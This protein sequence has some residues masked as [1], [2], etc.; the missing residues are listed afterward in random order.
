MLRRR[1]WSI[2]GAALELGQE[3]SRGYTQQHKQGM[4]SGSSCHRGFFSGGNAAMSHRCFFSNN[5]FKMQTPGITSRPRQGFLQ[6]AVSPVWLIPVHPTASPAVGYEG[7]DTSTWTA[8]TPSCSTRQASWETMAL[9][10][11]GLE[12]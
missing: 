10:L 12:V 6:A 4:L 7:K 2:P 8:M 11:M 1:A 5:Q 3:H 9:A